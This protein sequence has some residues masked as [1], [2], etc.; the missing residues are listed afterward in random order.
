MSR[1]SGSSMLKFAS[2]FRSKLPATSVLGPAAVTPVVAVIMPADLQN[3][4]N[5]RSWIAQKFWVMRNI[6]SEECIIFPVWLL[7]LLFFGEKCCLA[8]N[9]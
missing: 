2:G 5:P 8:V 7:F 4:V 6:F 1:G 3:V 9:F